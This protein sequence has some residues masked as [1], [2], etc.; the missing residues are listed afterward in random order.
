MLRRSHSHFGLTSPMSLQTRIQ[1]IKQQEGMNSLPVSLRPC[2]KTPQLAPTHRTGSP[3][4]TASCSR[5]PLACSRALL[6]RP[7][8]AT[9]SFSRSHSRTGRGPSSSAAAA[10]LQQASSTCAKVLTSVRSSGRSMCP[11]QESGRPQWNTRLSTGPSLATPDRLSR[12]NAGTHYRVASLHHSC[13][14][15]QCNSAGG[16]YTDLLAARSYIASACDTATHQLMWCLC[17]MDT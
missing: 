13:T 12:L 8:S 10:I 17:P 3:S 14:S 7:H 5:T 1:T 6:Q 15:V 2:L 9:P 16:L 4:G 11:A